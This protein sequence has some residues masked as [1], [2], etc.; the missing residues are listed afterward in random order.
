MQ[1]QTKVISVQLDL[2]IYEKL[3]QICATNEQ[4]I[5]GLIRLLLKKH[6]A[7]LEEPK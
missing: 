6:L 7:S 3:K 5:Q 2:D 4:P 1:K